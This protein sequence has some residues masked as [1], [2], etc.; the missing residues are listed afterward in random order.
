MLL[1]LDQ[2]VTAL[3]GPRYSL[4]PDIGRVY[5]IVFVEQ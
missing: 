1:Q 2:P 3:R 5:I 4:H